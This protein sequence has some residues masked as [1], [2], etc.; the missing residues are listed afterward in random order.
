MTNPILQALG[1]R[2][3][4]MSDIGRIKHMMNMVRSAGN[5]NAMLNSMMQ[6]NPQLR[7][8]FDII[9]QNGGDPRTAFYK[10]AEQKGVDPEE[11]LKMLR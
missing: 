8:V 7:Q 9:N 2:S 11:V 4:P 5:P 1:N 6:S 3:L 10:L